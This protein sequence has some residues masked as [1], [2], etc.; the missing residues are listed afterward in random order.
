MKYTFENTKQILT[1]DQ[2]ILKIKIL[3]SFIKTEQ[4]YN[5]IIRFTVCRLF[6]FDG[7]LNIDQACL[8][9]VQKAIEPP[10]LLNQNCVHRLVIGGRI[11]F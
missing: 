4:F 11:F 5:L 3:S 10:H 6:T 7:F 9:Y 1:V 2:I 8:D